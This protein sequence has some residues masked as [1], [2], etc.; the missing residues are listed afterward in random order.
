M[1][2]KGL[3]PILLLFALVAI[4]AVAGGAYYFVKSQSPK[5]QT[6]QII[7]TPSSIPDASR[8]PN[9]PAETANWK[10]YAN[11]KL[12]VSF[13]IPRNWEV[14]EFTFSLNA[15]MEDISMGPEGKLRPISLS[16]ATRK[17]DASE[18]KRPYTITNEIYSVEE[19]VSNSSGYTFTEYV[20][21]FKGSLKG[22][23]SVVKIIEYNNKIVKWEI[24]DIALKNTF[25]R[26]LSTFKFL[27]SLEDTNSQ[28][29]FCGGFVGKEC[30]LGY[31]CILDGKYP[32]AG[33]KCAKE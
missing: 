11:A 25:D 9:G 10:T 17:T 23:K 8:E 20:L 13:N 27:D 31:T 18:L 30:P 33:G 24:I 16:V 3:A 14:Q 22:K 5:P 29:E 32:D 26:I 4:I 6:P 21:T 15:G 28:G 19:K 12:G 7:S 2:Q 1:S